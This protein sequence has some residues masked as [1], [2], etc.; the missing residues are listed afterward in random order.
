MNDGGAQLDY[1]VDLAEP[2]TSP[3]IA[4]VALLGLVVRHLKTTPGRGYETEAEARSVRRQAG[5]LA[6]ARYGVRPQLRVYRRD[7]RRGGAPVVTS[8]PCGSE[9]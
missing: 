4:M 7:F 3:W 5:R 6:W 8:I 2:G 1:V 9:A